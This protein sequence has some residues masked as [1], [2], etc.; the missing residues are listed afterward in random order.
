VKARGFPAFPPGARHGR[1]FARTWWGNAW[2]KALEDTSLDHSLLTRGRKFAHAGQVGSITVSPGRISA[3]VYG[4]DGT[5]HQTRV[6]VDE[7]S[8]AEWDRFLGQVA[9]KAGHIAALLDRDMP[10]ELVDAAEDAGVKLLPGIGDLEPECDCP[11]WGHPCQHAAALCYQVSWLL[12]TD[13][14]V[15][16]LMRGRDEDEILDV[17]RAR[18]VPGPDAGVIAALA[19]NAA[20][21]AR[22]LLAGEEPE[23]DRWRDSVRIAALEP[24]LRDRLRAGKRFDRAVRAWEF[25]G[26]AGLE[27]LES[28][29]TPPKHV[30]AASWDGDDLPELENHRNH[31]TGDGVQLRYGRDGR[32]YP[33]REEAGEW[34][35]AGPPGTDPSALWAIFPSL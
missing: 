3:Q 31:W 2:I 24:S 20:A 12:D 32:W 21:V 1:R 4:A 35:P 16:L 5:L 11:D 29:W 14:F 15:L 22:G 18:P 25:G 27:T 23:T 13:P 34:W 6:F 30:L 10:H 8:A 17:L 28:A 33:Y 26:A 19:R 7:L 9:A